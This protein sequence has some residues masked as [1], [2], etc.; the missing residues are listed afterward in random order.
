MVFVMAF[1]IASID[2]KIPTKAVIPMAIIAAVMK[3]LSAWALR[4]E[5]PWRIFSRISNKAVQK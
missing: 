2:V 3:A 4:D 1:P 5:N